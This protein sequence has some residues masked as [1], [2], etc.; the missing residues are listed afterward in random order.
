MANDVLQGAAIPA[1]GQVP[2]GNAFWY[3]PNVPRPCED[4]NHQERVAEATRILSDAGWTWDV[5]PGWDE[6]NRDVI[7]KGE[8]LRGP[9][10]T[11]VGD[12]TLLAPGPGYDPLRAEP[13]GFNVIVD[14]IFTDQPDFDMYILG[15]TLT[16]YPDHVADFFETSAD[17]ALGGLNTPGYS[18]PDLDALAAQLKTTSDVNEARSLIAEMDA[19]LAV[20][21]PYVVLFT[22]PILEAYSSSIRFPFTEVVDGIQNLNGLTSFATKA[23][24]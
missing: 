1:W 2:E 16:P 21:Q 15:W 20:E 14:R 8:G 3:D 11:P 18:N 4:L 6:D 10:G 5:E 12:L 22:T 7:P 23:A 19:I 9:D 17:A 13:T 24:D